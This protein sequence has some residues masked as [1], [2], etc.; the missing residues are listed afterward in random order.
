[1]LQ[2]LSCDE[3]PAGLARRLR[4]AAPD[5]RKAGRTTAI[6]ATRVR[7]HREARGEPGIGQ[8]GRDRLN[9]DSRLIGLG[10]HAGTV[11]AATGRA[12]TWIG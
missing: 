11:V 10:I 2:R 5:E 4:V 9:G 6:S 1:M 3:T 12:A 8:Q 7:R